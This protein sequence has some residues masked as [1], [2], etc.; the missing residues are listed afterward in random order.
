MDESLPRPQTSPQWTGAPA[1]GGA[2]G[3]FSTYAPV[4]GVHDE[5]YASPGVPREAWVRFLGDLNRLGKDELARRWEQASQLV[6]EN[7]IAYSAYGDPQ[8]QLRPW[9]LDAIPLLLAEREWQVVSDGLRQRVRLLELVLQDLYGPQRLLLEGVLPAKV[10][11]EHPGFQPAIHGY[12]PLGGRFLCTYAADLARGSEGSW[13]V[14]A[15]RTEAPSG[16]GFALENRVVTSRLLPSIFRQSNVRRLAPYFIALQRTLQQLAPRHRENPRIVIMSQGADSA[17]YFEDAYL[18]RYLG[19]T[20]VEGGDLT[21]RNGEVMLKTLGGLLPVDVILRR[22]NSE[23]CD[24]LELNGHSDLGAAGILQSARDGNVAIVNGMGSGLVESPVMMAFLPRISLHLLGEPLQLPAV[25]TWWCG[26]K[27]SLAY[28]VEHFDRMFIQ[29]AY[30]RRGLGFQQAKWMREMS[31]QQLLDELLRAPS[32]YVAQEKMTRSSVPL[33]RDEELKSAFVSLRAFLVADGDDYAVMDGALART[34]SASESLEASLLMGEGSKDT[35]ILS[36]EPV[37]PVSLLPPRGETLRLVRSRADLPSRVADNLYW[38]GR[39]IERVDSAAR[40]LRTVALRL[41]SENDA[42]RL[43]ELHYL[44]RCMAEQGQIEPGFALEGMRDQLPAIEQVLPQMVFDPNQ[45]GSL[46]SLVDQTYR[47]ASRVRDRISVDSW[48]VLTAINA[49][50]QLGEEE[51]GDFSTLLRHTN[52]LIMNLAAFGGTVTESMTRTQAY[53]FLELGRRLERALQILLTVGNCIIDVHR[54]PSE[55]LEALLEIADSR[56]TYRS[57]Y[58]A[59]L[60]LAPVLDLILTDETN[61]RSLAYQLVALQEHVAGL[62]RL[63]NTPVYSPEQRLAMS[64][65]HSI[66]MMDIETICETYS[67]GDHEPLANLMADW[68]KQLPMLSNVVSMRYLVH[69]GPSQLLGE[70]SPQ[71]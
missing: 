49:D 55:L 15:D 20:L 53:R 23:S 57:R 7:G 19:Y 48:R 31:R 16:T 38:L 61:P 13:H 63:L 22:P 32:A 25:P 50:F 65:V 51:A 58:L 24:P 37:E 14:L 52:H 33:Y 12:K 67:L 18:A 64:L 1:E 9:E 56:M 27:D 35:W 6:Y 21:V 3:I 45:S 10:F 43:P 2:A 40:L 68:S 4:A 5:A 70:L 34:S 42:N 8:A 44:L 59:N 69:A 71:M 47:T 26:E 11:H 62:P 54:V 28:V 39:Q 17:N 46:R 30:R 60:Q 36:Q 41:S 29:P 66:R